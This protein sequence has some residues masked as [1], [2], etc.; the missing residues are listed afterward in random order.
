MRESLNELFLPAASSM[1]YLRC[2]LWELNQGLAFVREFLSVF[3]RSFL[4]AYNVRPSVC[5]S[6][7]P[8]LREQELLGKEI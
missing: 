4:V 3:V 6:A 1:A 5:R 8:R 7:T 2:I